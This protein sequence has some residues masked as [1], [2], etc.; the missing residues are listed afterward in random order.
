MSLDGIKVNHAGLDTGAQDLAT[1]VKN[2]ENRLQQLEDELSELK[3]A[4]VGNARLAYDDAKRKWDQAILE[5][6]DLLART[7]NAVATANT[8]Y[9]E[10]DKRGAGLFG[11]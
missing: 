1:G 11:G 4:W 2:I 3:G 6:K 10:A 5:M 9:R 7:S 8:E